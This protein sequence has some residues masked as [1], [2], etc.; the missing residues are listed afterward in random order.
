MTTTR[1]KNWLKS[2]RNSDFDTYAQLFWAVH[3]KP[4]QGTD[5]YGEWYSDGFDWSKP[6]A[7]ALPTYPARTRWQLISNEIGRRGC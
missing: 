3:L 1:F 7:K 4:L 2:L 5:A 6:N